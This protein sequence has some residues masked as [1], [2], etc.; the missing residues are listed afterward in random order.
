MTHPG[1]PR[2]LFLLWQMPSIVKAGLPLAK[3]YKRKRITD[4][5]NARA[6]WAIKGWDEKDFD[7]ENPWFVRLWGEVNPGKGGDEIEVHATMSGMSMVE[8]VA[9]VGPTMDAY[10]LLMT[11]ERFE[12]EYERD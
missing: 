4:R 6:D 5:E 7:P 1:F 12:Q 8:L 9:F 11:K 2:S 3:S 10:P